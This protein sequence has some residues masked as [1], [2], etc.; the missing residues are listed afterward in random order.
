MLDVDV[1]PRSLDGID[2]VRFDPMEQHGSPLFRWA[3]LLR[4]IKM[5]IHSFPQ[6][7]GKAKVENLLQERR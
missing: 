4:A 5:V 2:V 7:C 3:R 1:H 6:I